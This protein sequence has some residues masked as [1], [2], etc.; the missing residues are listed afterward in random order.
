MTMSDQ[1]TATSAAPLTQATAP[2]VP[3]TTPA[4][5]AAPA[6]AP[7]ATDWTSGLAD[8]TKLYVQQKGFKD[9][10]A[11]VDSYRNF[12]K[13]Q[14][15]PAENVL[16][17][18]TRPDDIEGWNNV[19]NRLGRP[20]KP[21]EYGITVPEKGGDPEFAKFAAG[22]FHEAGISKSQGEKIVN[23][24]NER[25]QNQLKATEEARTAALA[26]EDKALRVEWG[27]AWE[28]NV[29]IGEKAANTFG[30]DDKQLTAIEQALGFSATMKLFHNIGAKLGEDKFV[31]A[32]GNRGFGG[33]LTPAQARGRIQQLRQ[34][35]D[36][37]KR[38]LAGESAAKEQMS[39]LHQQA[40][41]ETES[42]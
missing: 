6:P 41:P 25:A 26:K 7:V 28:Q 12:E 36:F 20:A 1:A 27:Q 3:S 32:D 8:E 42:A 35:P 31:V 15:V 5:Q 2:A 39:S 13:L 30:L 24:W 37:T 21:E 16:K 14:G 9:I 22:V 29:K 33:V 4:V 34:D 18:P 11:V 38:Y 10:G 17:L 40:Y 19:Y 23:K